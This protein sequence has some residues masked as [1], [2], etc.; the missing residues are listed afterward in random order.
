MRQNQE[1]RARLHIIPH[2]GQVP[3]TNVTAT[4]LRA[5][6]AKLE[7]TVASVDSRRGIL[8]E[9]SSVLEAAVDDKRLAGNPMRSKSVRRT[10][11]S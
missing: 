10:K 3:L 2:V 11:A 7:A 4:G 6:T 9:L 8:S 1:R 5:Y